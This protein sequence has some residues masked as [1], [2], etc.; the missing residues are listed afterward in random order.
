MD[1]LRR[2]F[3]LNDIEYIALHAIFPL[4]SAVLISPVSLEDRWPLIINGPEHHINFLHPLMKHLLKS[5]PLS[6]EGEGWIGVNHVNATSLNLFYVYEDTNPSSLQPADKNAKRIELLQSKFR[7]DAAK[8]TSL[9]FSEISVIEVV[10]EGKIATSHRVS[11]P[12]DF[13]NGSITLPAV[14]L[15]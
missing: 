1:N 8:Y 6:S 14:W 13:K 4:S 5:S 11:L 9:K 12:P 10:W 3:G 2:F 7:N 15:H